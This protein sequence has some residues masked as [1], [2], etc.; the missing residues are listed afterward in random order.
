MQYTPPEALETPTTIRQLTQWMKA[1]CNNFQSYSIDGSWIWEGYGLKAEED[2]FVWYYTERGREEQLQRFDTE[3]DA[4]G[5]AYQSILGDLTA[6]RHMIGFTKSKAGASKMEQTLLYRGVT[7][8]TDRIL[9]GPK[10]YRYRVFVFGC[11]VHKALDL[12]S[13]EA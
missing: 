11:D 13:P 12:K 7:S 5:F 2:C 8:F 6:W 3:V 1:N 9:Y 4:V 10:D